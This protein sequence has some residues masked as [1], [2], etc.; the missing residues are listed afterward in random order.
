MSTA[1]TKRKPLTAGTVK[2]A[3]VRPGRRIT[4]KSRN[5]FTTKKR[6]RQTIRKV[7][8]VLNEYVR[9]FA[10]FFMVLL[11]FGI[12]GGTERNTI[13]MAVGMKMAFKCLVVAALLLMPEMT[14]F[15][16]GRR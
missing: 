6:R 13:E 16:G 2:G 10:G 11:M 14:F 9:P 3:G 8:R 4:Y 1:T 5:H 7:I 15:N 12:I